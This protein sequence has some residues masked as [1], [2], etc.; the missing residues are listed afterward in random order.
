[1]WQKL[2]EKQLLLRLFGQPNEYVGIFVILL[3]CFWPFLGFSINKTQ[4][5]QRFAYLFIC[6]FVADRLPPSPH[7]CIKQIVEPKCEE[8]DMGF[9][10]SRVPFAT[11]FRPE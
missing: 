2:R 7:S 9:I 5:L 4:L 3:I 1:M 10:F 8:E 11:A 6:L